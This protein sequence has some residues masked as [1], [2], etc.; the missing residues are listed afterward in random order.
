MRLRPV[1]IFSALLLLLIGSVTTWVA[2]TIPNDVRAEAIL[3][4]ARTDLRDGKRDDSKEKLR[5][6]IRRYPRTDAAAAA[7]ETL[8][9]LTEQDRQRM[10]KQLADEQ[11]ARAQLTLRLAALEQRVSAAVAVKPTT[12]TPAKPAGKPVVKK[13]TKTS[14]RRTTSRRKS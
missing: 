10:Q 8:F 12:V 2:L 11:R 13:P 7:V 14:Q 4:R 3:K 1:W 5:T 9:E 6:L